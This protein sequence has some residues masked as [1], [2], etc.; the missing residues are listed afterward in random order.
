[1]TALS[2]LAA[3]AKPVVSCPDRL[4]P[5]VEAGVLAAADVHVARTICGLMG[6]DDPEVLL[7]V[8]CAARA[9]RVGHSCLDMAAVADGVVAEIASRDPE[10][11][12]A[13][14]N[15]LEWPDSDQWLTAVAGSPVAG[16]P[17]DALPL[18]VEDGLVFLRRQYEQEVTLAD[19]LHSRLMSNAVPDETQLEELLGQMFPGMAPDD[20]QR[21][22]CRAAVSHRLS[23]V[24]GGPG[25]GKT[26]IVARMLVVMLDQAHA[27]DRAPRIALAAPTAKAAAQLS[28]SIAGAL[29]EGLVL[30]AE[31]QKAIVDAGRGQ[32][33]HG[34]LGRKTASRFWHDRDRPLP[35]DI[36]VIDETSMASLSLMARLLEAVRPDAQLVLIGDPDQL[37]SVEAGKVLADIVD[38]LDGEHVVR[39]T[40][41]H[42]FAEGSG[43]GLLAAAIRDGEADTAI[44]MLRDRDD[45]GWIDVAD[46]TA[47]DLAPIRNRVVE[48]GRRLVAAALAGD[49]VTARACLKE[50]IILT[51]HRRGSMGVEGWNRRV[52]RWYAE[53][54]PGWKPYDDWP[55]GRVVLAT[56]NDRTLGVF[57]GDLGVVVTTAEGP[58]LAF[59]DDPDRLIPTH[60]LQQHQR[61]HGM[62]IHKSQGSQWN[63]VLVSLPTQPSRLLTR[64]LLYTACTRAQT[65]LGV[66]GQGSVLAAGVA[67]QPRFRSRGLPDPRPRLA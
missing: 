7:A 14:L 31:V 15:A 27:Q 61:V 37:P 65:D 57:N 36:V 67:A 21:R 30:R 39:L 3:A 32:T 58:R 35:H 5:F 12:E 51:P 63:H 20:P 2:S 64:S 24:T 33:I 62:T 10:E 8:A 66:L 4:W 22:A 50:L 25:T 6:T 60:R 18:V 28:T 59:H 11:Q 34:L 43:I 17:E 42:R 52:D 29:D 49:V 19:D 53:S 47:A 26:W 1:M 40:K 38:V 41:S 54:V 23:V 48:R 56:T 9:P 13:L 44:Q 55:P 16:R 46:P 45:L